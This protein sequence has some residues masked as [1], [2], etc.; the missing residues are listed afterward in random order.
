MWVDKSLHLYNAITRPSPPRLGYLGLT[1]LA[2]HANVY[3]ALSSVKS[4]K[5]RERKRNIEQTEK[6]GIF[7]NLPLN[8]ARGRRK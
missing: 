3:Q 5:R 6:K 4:V 7:I 8:H 1:Y 2:H